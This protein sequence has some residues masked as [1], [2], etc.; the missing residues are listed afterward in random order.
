MWINIILGFI[1]SL[2]TKPTKLSCCL[3]AK[4]LCSWTTQTHTA[5]SM[6][7]VMLS[8]QLNLIPSA[9]GTVSFYVS[10]VSVFPAQSIP[11]SS[12][13]LLWDSFQPLLTQISSLSELRRYRFK[14]VPWSRDRRPI[15]FL[16][17]WADACVSGFRVVLQNARVMPW[18]CEP[19]D[20]LLGAL[21]L[22]VQ[23][24][25]SLIPGWICYRT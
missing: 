3:W 18:E 14:H 12:A 2:S 22:W 9:D 24:V 7:N 17:V 5:I 10:S 8:K 11:L 4:S 13:V 25:N 21:L 15:V 19:F 23:K 16:G 1:L 6:T 20:P